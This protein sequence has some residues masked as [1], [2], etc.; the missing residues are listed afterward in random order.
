MMKKLFIAVLI[1][2][3]SLCV[4]SSQLPSVTLAWDS[5]DHPE[6]VGY[7]IYYRYHLNEEYSVDRVY[8]VAEADLAN[9]LLP[10]VTLYSMPYGTLHYFVATAYTAAEESKYSNE[11]S[12]LSEDEP[13][14]EPP[15]NGGG[16]GGGGCFIATV[17]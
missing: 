9:P 1:L 3:T 12:W 8:E 6:L 16:G 5:V 15:S 4:W 13:K 7:N 10:E 17:Q 11:V 2:V 14:S